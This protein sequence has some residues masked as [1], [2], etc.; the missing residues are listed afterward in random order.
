MIF[1]REGKI[2]EGYWERWEKEGSAWEEI[3]KRL[4]PWLAGFAEQYGMELT[5][6][7]WDAPDRLLTWVGSD[8]L[9]RN[10]HVYIKSEAAQY[11]MTIEASVWQDIY[12]PNGEGERH[13]ATVG[14]RSVEVPP[15]RYEDLAIYLQKTWAPVIHD[16]YRQVMNIIKWDDLKLTARLSSRV[17]F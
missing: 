3:F 7:H 4:D 17:S 16:I 12:G 5:K 11:E 2:M 8:G 14:P 1:V 10:I 15:S 9:H 6:E 13:Y